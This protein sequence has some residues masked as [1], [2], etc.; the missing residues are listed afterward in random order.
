MDCHVAFWHESMLFLLSNA[1][2]HEQ[3]VQAVAVQ[4]GMPELTANVEY[5]TE[6]HQDL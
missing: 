2:G 5:T 4:Y 6:D 3:A 1:F